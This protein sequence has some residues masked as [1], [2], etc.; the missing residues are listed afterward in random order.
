MS[1]GEEAG[2]ELLHTCIR[3][4]S[5]VVNLQRAKSVI[6]EIQLETNG[7]LSVIIKFSV[8]NIE[9]YK[10]KQLISTRVDHVHYDENTDILCNLKSADSAT[11]IFEMVYKILDD[12]YSINYQNRL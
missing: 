9:L 5:V 2:E 4:F 3:Q 10:N 7:E 12:L 11:T 1:Q 6:K 8:T